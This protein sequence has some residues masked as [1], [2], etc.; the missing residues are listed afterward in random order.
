MLLRLLVGVLL[1]AK[2]VWDWEIECVNPVEFD[3]VLVFPVNNRLFKLAFDKSKGR[4]V[5]KLGLKVAGGF[6]DAPDSFPVNKG[7]LKVLRVA[8]KSPMRSVCAEVGVDGILVRSWDVT[9]ATFFKDGG[10]W[11][12]KIFV[13]GTYKDERRGVKSEVV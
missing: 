6:G 5:K 1:L 7:Y 4:I 9:G 2:V 12:C 3:V 8:I 10:A 13:S 11:R